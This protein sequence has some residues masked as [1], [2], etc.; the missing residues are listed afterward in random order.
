MK[1]IT[2]LYLAQAREFLRDR[3]AVL[4]VLL[5]PVV[6]GVF[7]GLVFSEG[8][9]FT[10][11]LGLANEDLGSVGDQIVMNLGTPEAKG[12]YNLSIGERDDLM[13]ILK[14]GDLHA[15]L[16]LP[17]N[18]SQSVINGQS[19]VIEVF[20][21]TANPTSADFAVSI[22]R[23]LLNEINLALSGSPPILEMAPQPVQTKPLR[24]IDFFM[25][26]MLGVALLWL[27][28]FGTAQP[29]VSQRETQ[30]LRRIGV[31]PVSRLTILTAEVGWR[32][33]VGL[34]QAPVFL[35][36]GYFGFGVGVISWPPFIGAIVL[37]TLVFVSLGYVLAGLGRSTESVMAIS[38]LINFPMMMLSGSIFMVE[39]LPDLFR[40]IMSALPLT[41]LSDLLR[42]SMVGAPAMHPIGLDFAVLGGWLVVLF[43]LAVKLWRWE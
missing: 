28:I 39:M 16:V 33:T 7:F 10:L 6:F 43:I 23:T 37:G 19:A 17:E 3:S 20:Y 21:D 4:F 24:S 11:Q 25:P 34:L 8:G 12:G 1:A 30:I 22:V 38:Q 31:T 26:G 32:V 2:A 36:V 42:Q 9:S 5:L 29:I 13:P 41:Y 27:G 40:P 15:L 18:L 35:L 14:R